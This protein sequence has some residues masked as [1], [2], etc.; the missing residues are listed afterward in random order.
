[1]TKAPRDLPWDRVHKIVGIGEKRVVADDRSRRVP[2]QMQESK[3][4]QEEAARRLGKKT[5]DKKIGEK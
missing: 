5:T 1:M 2:V 3:R 4:M